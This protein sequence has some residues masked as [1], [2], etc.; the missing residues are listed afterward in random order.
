MGPVR[1][2]IIGMADFFAVILIM[3]VTIGGAVLG[4]SYGEVFDRMSRDPH[5]SKML[6]GLLG[7]GAI[8]F[9]VSGL[10]ASF[11]FALSEIARN[12]YRTVQIL[13]KRDSSS[14]W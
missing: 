2:A 10:L 1:R 5:N 3:G 11:T 9:I 8:G 13:E 4:A 7:G 12:T 14:D 6:L